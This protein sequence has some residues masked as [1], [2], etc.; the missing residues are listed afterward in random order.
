MAQDDLTNAER[1]QQYMD[2]LPV[3]EEGQT[4]CFECNPDVAC[5]GR[6]CRQLT[7]PLTPYDVLRLR[8][9]LGM[10]SADFLTTLTTMRTIPDSGLP[11]PMLKMCGG[12]EE[13]CPFLTPTG[14]QVYD[15]RP[16]A[17][18]SYPIGRGTRPSPNG[19]Y[20]T[21]YLVQE[22]HCRGFDAGR[23]WTA[24]EWFEREGLTP[25]NNANDRYMRLGAMI[26]ASGRPLED[27]L[28]TMCI[29]CCYQLDRFR[30]LVDRMRIFERVRVDP[31]R[32]AAVRDHD[33]DALEF[34]LD[35][36][37]LVIF[38]TCDG[39]EKVR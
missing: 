19:V 7:L 5:F 22:D 2:S 35:W 13:T 25:Y 15:D 24:Q 12:P 1:A 11:I 20:E 28:A 31:A 39:L 4:F 6:C 18:R 3:L 17:C 8:R 21:H 16:G 30:E 34:G 23:D 14:C 29:L 33:E 38:G 10:T 37:E 9:A 36:M 26:A 27:R 32:Q